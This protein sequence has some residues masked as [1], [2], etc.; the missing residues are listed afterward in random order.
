MNFFRTG[1]SLALALVLAVTWGLW[2][3]AVQAA[4]LNSREEAALFSLA[5]LGPLDLSPKTVTVELYVSPDPEL[6]DCRRMLAQVWEQ[7]QQFYARM[8]VNLLGVTDRPAPL[9]PAKR[10][11]IELLTD[12][13]WLTQSFHAFDVA[14]PFQLRFLQICL[15]KCAFAHLNLS[16]IHISFKRFRKAELSA[17]AKE[18]GLNRHW[19]ANLMIHE[20]GHLLGLYHSY[21]FTNDPVAKSTKKERL[22]NFMSQDIAFKTS[23]GFVDFQKRQVHSYLSGGK[24]FQQYQQVNFDP[25]R[26]LELVKRY[27]GFQEPLPLKATKM[28]HGVKKSKKIK[29]FDDNDEDDE[30]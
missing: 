28:A 6:E 14:P 26:Y 3:A 18:A 13:Q 12:K 20:L 17:D 27:N 15:D 8:G 4:S 16:T 22:P 25:L 21:E 29:T 24:V 11:R 19:L 7:V 9:A 10:L 23:L 5:D 30:D 2:G 1:K